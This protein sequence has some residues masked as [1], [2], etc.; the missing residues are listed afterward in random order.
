M[1]A[2]TQ[3]Q[4]DSEQRTHVVV[5]NVSDRERA[6]LQPPQSI[7]FETGNKNNIVHHR[8]VQRVLG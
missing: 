7:R 1:V 4:R 3:G 6:V 2:M 5:A 8:L